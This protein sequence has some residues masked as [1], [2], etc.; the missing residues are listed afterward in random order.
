[1]SD[2]RLI[3]LTIEEFIKH[4][5]PTIERIVNKALQDKHNYEMNDKVLTMN[6]LVKM[7][8]IGGRQKILT[9]VKKGIIKQ[10]ADNLFSLKSVN[11]YINSKTK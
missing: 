10:T 1:M 5:E 8:V 2:N 7:K 9:L 6:K 4:I 11:E 3:D